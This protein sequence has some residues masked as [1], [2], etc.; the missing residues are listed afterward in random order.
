M[1]T[2]TLTGNQLRHVL[3][4]KVKSYLYEQRSLLIRG[5]V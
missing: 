2:F 3:T 1:T 5:Y 4:D